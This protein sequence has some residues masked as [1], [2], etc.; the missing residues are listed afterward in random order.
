MNP[1]PRTFIVI[2]VYNRREVTL[3]CL[4]NLRA[5]GVLRWAQVIVVDDGSTDGTGEAVT[6]ANP[7][8]VVLKGDGNLWWGGAMKLGMHTAMELGADVI[9]WLN[10]DCHARP[11][12]LELMR[13]HSLTT[14]EIAVAQT[15]ALAGGIFTGWRKTWRGLSSVRVAAGLRESCDTFSGNC[16]A[17]PR[18][19][20]ERIGGPDAKS[21]P[22][23]FCD[24]DFGLRAR[25]AG[26]KA[27]V[28]GDAICDD[29]YTRSEMSSSW[30]L[31]ERSVFA[32]W[33]S[34]RSV[35]SYYYPPAYWTFCIRHWKWWGIALFVQP[36]LKLLCHGALRTILPRRVL[37]M[38][39]GRLS[40][41]WRVQQH[42]PAD[43]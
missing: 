10:D 33:R 34:F 31:G 24:P 38:L 42:L 41:E 13:N 22:H 8:V 35:K 19:V 12:A 23:G 21:L 28:L 20:V 1:T 7:G 27:T 36:Y 39:F 30:L 14:G 29:Q 40:H 9:F 43:K 15:M 16:V 5:G 37:G 3:G 25:R 11:G 2:P 32:V 4:E 6:R 18:A 17:I 26:F